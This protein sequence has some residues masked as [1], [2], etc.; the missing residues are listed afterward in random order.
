MTTIPDPG[1]RRVPRYS[2]GEGSCVHPCYWCGARDSRD[3]R[4]QRGCPTL[5]P[6]TQ[7]QLL[8]LA[9]ACQAGWEAKLDADA[10][11]R[12]RGAAA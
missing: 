1:V 11:R 3:E 7:E 2:K 6:L 8:A 12:A 4:H 9:L 5:E 10:E